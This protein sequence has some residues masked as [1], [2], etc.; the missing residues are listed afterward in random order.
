MQ[1]GVARTRLSPPWGVELAGWGYYLE[2]TWQRVRDHTAAT[3]IV[4]DDD[5]RNAAAILALDVMYLDAANTRSIRDYVTAATGIPAKAI[6]VACSHSHNTPTAGFIRGA[7]EIDTEYLRWMQRQAATA[8]ILAWRG[9]QPASLGVAATDISGWTYNRTRGDGPV[10]TKLTVWRADTLDG[11][12]LAAVVNFQAHPTIMMSLGSTDLSRDAPG[13]ITDTLEAALPG[14]TAL[15]LQGS[16]GDINFGEAWNNPNRCHEPGRHVAAKALETWD[17]AR[18]HRKLEIANW[19][20]TIGN[21][22]ATCSL[23]VTLPTRR[24]TREEV[25]RD[26]EEGL[27]RLRTGDTAGWR[28]S[29]GRVMVNHPDRFAERYGGSL[30]LAVKAIARFAVEWT[31]EILKDLDTRPESLV[32]EVQ[33]I[34]IGNGFLVTDPAELFTTLALDVRRQWPHDLIIA[35]YANASIGYMPDGHDIARRTY[36]ADQSPKFKNQFPFMVE[37]GQTLVAGMVEALAR[38]M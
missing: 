25:L 30:E 31:A 33:A 11:R 38:V 16:C 27:H 21:S 6:C 9:R 3:A 37:S 10:D 28:E 13:L 29:I 7:G 35:G 32:T 2:R 12:P 8:A 4:F 26:R 15:Y 34:R 22:L 1:I 18:P 5:G 20:L 19:Q 17:A 24:W 23:P 14:L 36:A